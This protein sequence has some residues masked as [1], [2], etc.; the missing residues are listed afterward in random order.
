M[1]SRAIASMAR[2]LGSASAPARDGRLERRDR[3]RLGARDELVDLEVAL[4]RLADEQRPGH[5]APVAVDLGAEVEQEDGAVD[6][7]PIAGRAVRQR[8]LGPRQAGDVERERLGA[9]GPDQP[10]ESQR[11]VASR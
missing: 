8:R 7:R 2:P 9:A 4:G 10:L 3:G 5:V 6:D 1:T 11:E